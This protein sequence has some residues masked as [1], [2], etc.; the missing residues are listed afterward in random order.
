MLDADP[1]PTTAATAPTTWHRSASP[2]ASRRTDAIA[3]AVSKPH[4]L[5]E[6]T[7]LPPRSLAIVASTRSGSLPRMAHG[8]EIGVS[9]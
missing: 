3:H 8:F 5:D 1:P 2:G 7:N 9:V 6:T 4:R